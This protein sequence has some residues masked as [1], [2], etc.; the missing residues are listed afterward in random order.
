M[1]PELRDTL[2]Q[3]ADDSATL[4]MCRYSESGRSSGGV[5]ET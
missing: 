5:N 4:G 1:D 3:D 2:C